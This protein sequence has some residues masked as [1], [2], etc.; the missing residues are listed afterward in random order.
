MTLNLTPRNF[1]DFRS[2]I[3]VFLTELGIDVDIRFNDRVAFHG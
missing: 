3:K 1:L 2:R